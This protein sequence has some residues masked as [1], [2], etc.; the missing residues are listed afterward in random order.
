MENKYT[1]E[2]L[3]KA[4]KELEIKQVEEGAILKEQLVLTYESLKPV[5]FLKNLVKDVYSSESLK[6]ELI[7][8]AVSV[9][10]GL[11]SKKLVVRRSNNEVLKLLGLAVQLGITT[12]VSKKMDVLK[13]A[14]INFMNRFID[15]KEQNEEDN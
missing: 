12:F 6:D 7:N 13:D 1:S 10:S 9:A 8:T 5:N 14:A 3:K 4:I 15:K 11:V 2:S